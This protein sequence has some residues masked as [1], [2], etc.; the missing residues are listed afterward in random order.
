MFVFDLET[1]NNQ[2]FAEAN[3]AGFFA[4]NQLRDR[5][6]RDLTPDEI[7]IEK[8]NVTIFDESNGNPVMN[9]P[10]FISEKYD[11]YERTYINKDGNEIVS[12][13]RLFLLVHI[14]SGFDARVVLNSLVKEITELK[15]IKT[16]RGLTSL[17]FRCTVKIVNTCDAPRSVKFTCTKAHIKEAL[18]KIG[19]EH[20]LQPELLKGK[21]KHS[22]IKKDNFAD[23]D[24]FRSHIS[25]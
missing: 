17:L 11:E 23:L 24:L 12:S 8:E 15:I 4:V 7:V 16:D 3:A 14:S 1:H 22:V 2:E 10:K 6:D 13:F 20:G 18:E 9:M 21:I 5:W 19:G 25:N